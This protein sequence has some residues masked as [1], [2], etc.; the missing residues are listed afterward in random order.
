MIV[1]SQS[2]CVIS[3]LRLRNVM[4]K[5]AVTY[6]RDV[7]VNYLGTCIL[8]TVLVVRCPSAVAGSNDV[9][10]CVVSKHK[11]VI[12][13][14]CGKSCDWHTVNVRVSARRQ[15]RIDWFAV[16]DNRHPSAGARRPESRRVVAISGL[17]GPKTIRHF[18]RLS[19]L[20]AHTK[21]HTN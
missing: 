20:R 16:E 12:R 7:N 5:W 9:V 18:G 13:A 3:G 6:I 10:I 8:A 21:L 15:R 11:R 14:H 2:V 17:P 19:A 4:C 1:F